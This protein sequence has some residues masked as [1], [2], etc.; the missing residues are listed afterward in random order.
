MS[1]QADRPRGS[2]KHSRTKSKS[3]NR[4]SIPSKQSTTD[5]TKDKNATNAEIVAL[6]DSTNPTLPCWI[7][8]ILSTLLTTL[9]LVPYASRCEKSTRPLFGNLVSKNLLS[10]SVQ[11][12]VMA[13]LFA[14]FYYF[15]TP[16]ITFPQMQFPIG[17][18][19]QNNRLYKSI[20]KFMQLPNLSNFVQIPLLLLY[21]HTIKNAHQY[22]HLA[23]F[24]LTKFS[25]LY[26]LTS[27]VYSALYFP[28]AFLCA[29]KLLSA[30]S[31]G[32]GGAVIA[33]TSI[34]FG[35]FQKLDF[36]HAIGVETCLIGSLGL[37]VVQ[38]FVSCSQANKTFQSQSTS[39]AH[40][41]NTF[42]I[43][44]KSL[45]RQTKS[46]FATCMIIWIIIHKLLPATPR[47][48]VY[49]PTV[50]DT[51]NSDTGINPD[52]QMVSRLT[53]TILVQNTTASLTGQVVVGE[54]DAN[55][56]HGYSLPMRYLRVDHSLLGGL[57]MPKYPKLE[58]VVSIYPAFYLQEAAQFVLH[59]LS[60]K[61]VSEEEEEDEDETVDG[62]EVD[63]EQVEDE[64]DDIGDEDS[65]D[66]DF[67]VKYD[68]DDRDD[69]TPKI[70][71]NNKS[72]ILLGLG[73]GTATHGLIKQGYDV[74]VLE[75]DPAI[76]DAAVGFFGLDPNITSYIMDATEWISQYQEQAS[77]ENENALVKDEKHQ[78]SDNS[79]D[80]KRYD[81][82]IHDFFSSG[83]GPQHLLTPSTFSTL[84]D[85]I[86]V[87]DSGLLVVNL[88]GSLSNPRLL[89]TLLTLQ[90]VFAN[91]CDLFHDKVRL[92]ENEV[93]ERMVVGDDEDLNFVAICKQNYSAEQKYKDANVKTSEDH[94]TSDG[95][96]G[97][98]VLEFDYELIKDSV[99]KDMRGLVLST[100]E[101]RR[102]LNVKVAD[103]VTK[104][105]KIYEFEKKAKEAG[106][107][108]KSEQN[109]SEIK[110]WNVMARVLPA[111]AWLLY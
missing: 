53:P 28:F 43:F 102:V 108:E 3:N 19:V 17:R 73:I 33:L 106:Q 92:S 96:N 54:M 88:Y 74:S 13:T 9:S 15:V 82:V 61:H 26:T 100:L 24:Y 23:M 1:P 25:S 85:M 34:I 47:S 41:N 29:I 72:A 107:N 71:K 60:E 59:P 45:L 90:S 37:E 78:N 20:K 67:E 27:I 11:V 36:E 76:Y 6:L 44:L 89:E 86:L 104:L 52:R 31:N 10:T 93:K 4:K 39:H 5:S 14:L 97:D 40:K 63:V 8:Q 70:V 38:L 18:R 42:S 56:E 69:E 21:V 103:L 32:Y 55:K 30:V 35:I 99:G 48:F 62:E 75:I 65:E 49:I 64:S 84:R 87:P 66:V 109:D 68:E 58:G 80:L 2:G 77:A 22:G 81:I 105:D 50:S 57:W 111:H 51:A 12:T 46:A 16:Q 94:D 110:L 98:G 7:L 101:Q 91:G 83:N 79:T 95:S